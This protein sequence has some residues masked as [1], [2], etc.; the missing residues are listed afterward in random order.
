MDLTYRMSDGYFS[1][2]VRDK[3]Q[4]DIDLFGAALEQIWKLPHLPM[5]K[6]TLTFLHKRCHVPTVQ[7]MVLGFVYLP[8]CTSLACACVFACAH[9]PGFSAVS[10]NHNVLVA[11]QAALLTCHSWG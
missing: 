1:T 4:Q 3:R 10:V 2:P 5:I 8:V 11:L 9:A 7:G 6:N